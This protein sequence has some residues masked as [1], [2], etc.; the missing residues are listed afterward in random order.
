MNSLPSLDSWRQATDNISDLQYQS[1]FFEH[2]KHDLKVNNLPYVACVV[3]HAYACTISSQ[4][5]D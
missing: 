4:G 5:P 1:R 2:R 3:S